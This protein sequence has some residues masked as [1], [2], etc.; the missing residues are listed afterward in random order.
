MFKFGT[1]CCLYQ[2]SNKTSLSEAV[3]TAI[4]ESQAYSPEEVDFAYDSN[5]A[6]E[7]KA[8]T[9]LVPRFF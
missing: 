7:A 3:K 4:S 9:P 8:A 6:N 1:E 5:P 2:D